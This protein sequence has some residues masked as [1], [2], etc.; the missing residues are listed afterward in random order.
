MQKCKKKCITC[1]FSLKTTHR[2]SPSLLQT[3]SVCAVRGTWR[4]LGTGALPLL[5]PRPCWAQSAGGVGGAARALMWDVRACTP[6]LAALARS[7]ARR[8]RRRRAHPPSPARARAGRG[9]GAW[10]GGELRARSYGTCARARVT[11]LL[12]LLSSLLACDCHCHGPRLGP[13]SAA[14]VA[15]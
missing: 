11:C 3:H 7:R 10:G 15:A 8:A 2:H 14:G 4:A 12:V 1:S 5:R 13:R 9:R 6:H